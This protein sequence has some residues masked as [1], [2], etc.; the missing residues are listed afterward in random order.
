VSAPRF[1]DQPLFASVPGAQ[2]RD[3]G[4]DPG[5]GHHGEP[6]GIEPPLALYPPGPILLPAI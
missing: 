4:L 6:A 1:G 2:G 3:V 5:F